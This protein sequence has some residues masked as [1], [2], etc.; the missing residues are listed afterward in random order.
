MRTIIVTGGILSFLLLLFQS[1]QA[2]SVQWPG[3]KSGDAW[4]SPRLVLSNASEGSMEGSRS[5]VERSLAEAQFDSSM[6]AGR[7]IHESSKA[8]TPTVYA[9]GRQLGFRKSGLGTR[10]LLSVRCEVPVPDPPPSMVPEPSSIVLLGLGFATLFFAGAA[11]GR[12]FDAR[13]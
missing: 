4:V 7:L 2:S 13:S 9:S 5:P 12:M 6:M 3:E 10:G 8:L 11:R 1:A